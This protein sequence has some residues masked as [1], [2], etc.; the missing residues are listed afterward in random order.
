[1]KDMSFGTKKVFFII[2]F[3]FNSKT[4]SL[5]VCDRS[6]NFST[7]LFQMKWN[8][9][10]FKHYFCSQKS[11]RNIII[12]VK[13]SLS[14]MMVILWNTTEQKA[15]VKL[16]KGLFLILKPTEHKFQHQGVIFKVESAKI[17]PSKVQKVPFKRLKVTF[18]QKRVDRIVFNLND[19]A[20]SLLLN[21]FILE[22]WTPITVKWPKGFYI[23]L[24]FQNPDFI[25]LHFYV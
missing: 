10:I 16:L 9:N 7:F 23:W 24:K 2:I 21:F 19:C 4:I 25:L 17:Q 18:S 3:E 1:M 22:F 5:S 14:Q 20:K 6:R 11:I 13:V 15:H 8:W 12:A